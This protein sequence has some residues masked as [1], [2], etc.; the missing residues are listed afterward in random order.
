M[1]DGTALSKHSRSQNSVVSENNGCHFATLI[2]VHITSKN[3]EVRKVQA[4]K[5]YETLIS[6]DITLETW[7]QVKDHGRYRL[8]NSQDQQRD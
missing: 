1:N 5:R 6:L 3:V 4:L 7:S 8:K 2:Y